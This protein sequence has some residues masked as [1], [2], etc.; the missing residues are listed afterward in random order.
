MNEFIKVKL[1]ES[2]FVYIETTKRKD[3]GAIKQASLRN[4][5]EKVADRMFTSAI[6]KIK[7]VSSQ[8]VKSL[9][10]ISHRPDEYEI[11]FSVNFTSD[12]DV[13]IV[14]ASSE[15]AISIKMKWSSK[16]HE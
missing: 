9:D 12:L 5:G 10:D 6:D 11:E 8:I 7:S 16:Q 15:S 2:T 14:N 13:V 4:A 1:D 3:E